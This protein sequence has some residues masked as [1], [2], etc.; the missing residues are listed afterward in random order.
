MKK[1]IYFGTNLKMYKG[2]NEVI[3]YLSELGKLYKQHIQN[4]NIELFVIPSYTALSDATRL[5]N[6]ELD[7]LVIGAQN[8][9]HADSGQF[10]GEISPV[11]LK[12]LNVK[13]VM[14]GHSERRHIF[15]ETDLEENKKVLAALKHQFITLLCIGET[16]EQKEYSISD[17]ILRMQLKIGLHNVTKEQIPLIRV[18]YEP[19]WAIGEAGIPASAEYAENKHAVIKQCLSEMF[20]EVGLDI[21]VLYGGSVNPTN[22]NELINKQHIDGLFIG[23]SAWNAANFIQLMKNALEALSQNNQYQN[24]EFATT[25]SKL[26]EYLGGKQN[27]VALTHC[28][29]RIRVVLHN[30]EN[31]D[32][33]KIEKLPLVKGLF[34]IS[35]Q[36]QI[37]LGKDIVSMVHSQM[38][39][40][41]P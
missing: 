7:N 29:T 30:P 33:N 2:N 10:T 1:K 8:M 24:N 15:K 26:I 23:R 18:A 19:V 12:E 4:N 32:K 34:S 27:I 9:C 5:A 41:M 22:A 21:P 14:I 16:L 39:I 17:E 28:A 31:I 13:L 37:I 35:N 25:A 38:Q 20:G 40:Q 11:M 3:H 6:D 36:Y